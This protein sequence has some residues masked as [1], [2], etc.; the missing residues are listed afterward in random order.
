MVG[1]VDVELFMGDS[2]MLDLLLS[3]K[4]VQSADTLCCE[5]EGRREEG[6]TLDKT[7]FDPVSEMDHYKRNFGSQEWR[8]IL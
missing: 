7:G 3:I 1:G 8:G 6:C 4:V 2:V 5:L